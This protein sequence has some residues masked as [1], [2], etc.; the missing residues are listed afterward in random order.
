[1]K[2]VLPH[3][4]MQYKTEAFGFVLESNF[5]LFFVSGQEEKRRQYARKF[6]RA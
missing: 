4:D 5:K 3:I 1:M 6:D 2:P